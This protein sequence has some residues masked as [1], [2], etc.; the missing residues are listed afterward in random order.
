MSSA[1]S[2]LK[3]LEIVA[4]NPRV[5]L[6]ELVQLLD[7]PKTTTY[8]HLNELLETGW[9][10]SEGEGRNR[11]WVVSPKLTVLAH[12]SRSP[13]NLRNAALPIMEELRELSGESVHLVVAEHREVVL[14]ERLDSP[15]A[16]RAVRPIGGRMLMHAT[17]TGKAIL[18]FSS[19]DR[20]QRYLKSPLEQVTP[21][22][23]VDTETLLMEL[24]LIRERGF[25]TNNGEMD[26]QVRA[27]AAVLFT[28]NLEPAASI[29][30]SGPSVRISDAKLEAYG[31]L[32]RDTTQKFDTRPYPTLKPGR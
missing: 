8:R 4:K 11:R 32:V 19:N 26:A 23:I 2:A 24:E 3:V 31:K 27:A 25:A 20:L 1:K 16:L 12:L 29:S 18:A 7:E 28:G 15:Q 9:L 5:T 6:H 30:I 14:I 17:S 10:I 21:N 22:T 13:F